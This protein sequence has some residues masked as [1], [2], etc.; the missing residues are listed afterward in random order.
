MISGPD[1][2]RDSIQRMSN[3]GLGIDFGLYL[4]GNIPRINM[5]NLETLYGQQNTQLIC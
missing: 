5:E 3:L 4:E 2:D 1:I